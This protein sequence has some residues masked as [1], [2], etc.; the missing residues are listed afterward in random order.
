MSPNEPELAIAV[1]ARSWSDSLHRFLADHGGARVRLTAMGPDDLVGE[2]FDI[3]LIDDIC[4]FLTPRL[5]GLVRDAGR[6]VIGVYDPTEFSDGKERL[7]ECGVA[8]VVEA[9]AHPDEFLAAIG[10]VADGVVDRSTRPD[11]PMS[12][13]EATSAR[14]GSEEGLVAVGGPPGGPGATEV[15]ITLAHVLS[16]RGGPV[17]LVDLDLGS[18]SIAQRLSL[19][20]HPNIRSAIDEME[21]GAARAEGLLHPVADSL[22]ALPGLPNVGESTEV[23]SGQVTSVLRRLG[24]TARTVV[25]D[26]GGGRRAEDGSRESGIVADVVGVA[27]RVVAVGFGGPVGLARLIDWLSMFDRLAACGGVDVLINRAPRDGFRR[28]ELAD[29][30]RRTYS[31]RS[32]GFLPEDGKV[33]LAAWNGQ[34]VTG[35]RFHRAVD[36]WA[37]AFEVG[38]RR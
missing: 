18:P 24:E 19:E 33:E 37:A 31:P 14:I 11:G 15:A 13:P 23:R 34:L 26:L 17:V 7:A 2:A 27:D 1:S 32:L 6:M 28:N 3:L 22:S 10:R 30:L 4:S 21:F 36:R 12:A 9:T 35:G 38:S 25:V 5:V 16:V 8:D 20:L 29:E